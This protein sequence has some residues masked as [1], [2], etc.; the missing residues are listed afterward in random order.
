MTLKLGPDPGSAELDFVPGEPWDGGIRLKQA[1]VY[2]TWPAAPVI[3]F[4][5]GV[6]W[7]ATLEDIVVD[8]DTF[9]NARAVWSKD[10]TETTTAVIGEGGSTFRI[11]VDGRSWW[12]GVTIEK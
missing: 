2:T 6:Q 10:A 11:R 1:G 5:N 7:T 9:P 4:E 8:T 3:V 12:S